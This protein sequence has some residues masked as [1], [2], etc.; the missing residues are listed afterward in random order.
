MNGKTLQ[1][2]DVETAPRLTLS[3]ET[4]DSLRSGKETLLREREQVAAR[5]AQLDAAI[6]RQE[7]AIAVVSA[8]I[9]GE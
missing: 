2:L 9:A 8:L 3:Q 7:G 6:Q 1:V 5:L 4:L